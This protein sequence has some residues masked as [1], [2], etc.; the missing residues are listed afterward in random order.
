MDIDIQTTP[1]A[2]IRKSLGLFLIIFLLTGIV[3][4]GLTLAFY[5]SVTNTT[6]NNL[7]E[8]EQFEV[9]L[10]LQILNDTLSSIEGDILFLSQQN[11][12]HK[13]LLTGDKKWLDELASEYVLI[14]TQK[15]IYDQ[16]RFLD[17][18]G[19]E[20]VRVNENSGKPAKVP[21]KELQLKQN[22]Y[23]FEDCFKM[24]KEE[25]YLSPFDLNLEH[26]QIEIP[27]KP[28][29]RLGTP[30]FDQTGK[31]R[32]I[33]L[34]NYYGQ[35]LLDTIIQ[36]ELFSEG[37]T[38]LLNGEGYWLLNPKPELEWGFMFHDAQRTLAVVDPKAWMAIDNM[39]QGQIE[40]PKGIY[41]FKTAYPL[42]TTGSRPNTQSV[43][44]VGQ[45]TDGT[46]NN[47]YHWHLV[48]FLST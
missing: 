27:H 45:R 31:K 26:G 34:A 24:G 43:Q 38:M 44:A 19:M 39:D 16:I 8:K 13:Y 30:V 4:S 18:S 32:G 36:S 42:K 17:S 29:I 20:I 33:V 22:R 15:H 6:L 40:T 28:M 12:L 10:Q 5:H 48:S 23:Y 25:I 21:L 47:G 41:T 2:I 37:Q 35:K 3:F 14:A 46:G 7:K 1:V 11:E 9:D